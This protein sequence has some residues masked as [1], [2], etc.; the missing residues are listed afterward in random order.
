MRNESRLACLVLALAFSASAANT[1]W[2]AKEDP[3][4]SD[5]NVGTEEAPF[6]TI[7][8]A[9]DNPNFVAGDTVNVKRGY[10]DEGASISDASVIS[11]R[12]LITK[13]C[14]LIGVEGA[15]VTHIVGARS[16]GSTA[17]GGRGDY[18]TRC[19]FV[20][21]A[22]RTEDMV[23]EGF[24]L[25]NGATGGDAVDTLKNHGGAI[26]SSGNYPLVIDCVISNCAAYK[27]AGLRGGTAIRCYIADNWSASS[28]VAINGGKG[29]SCIIAYNSGS[30]IISSSYLC[31]CT[32]Y[33]NGNSIV[34]TG[35][36]GAYNCI[37]VDH[38]RPDT[39]K[40]TPSNTSGSIFTATNGTGIVLADRWQFV[41]PAAGDWRVVA[42]SAAETAGDGS[43]SA[44]SAF[45][46]IPISERYKD[47]YKNPIPETG[48]VM[49][50]AVQQS[51]Q[52]VAGGLALNRA[53]LRNSPKL[54]RL[55]HA[56]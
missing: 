25:R 18:A 31:H 22:A 7:Q 54:R 20:D 38:G 47:F 6:R 46:H 35:S 55:R 34:L 29:Y 51:A 14:H 12:V 17:S 41:G 11:N 27:G 19:I 43:Q 5:A 44:K 15:A 52:V 2:V 48:T 50:G 13:A 45:N 32:L 24:T 39:A 37:F 30:Q 23:I 16:P 53:H 26:Y 1:W 42:G 4:A 40:Y 10:Y 3:N 36:G 9:L 33:A 28:G 56:A 8:A 49:A 21:S